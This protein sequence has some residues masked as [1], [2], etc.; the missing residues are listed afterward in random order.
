MQFDYAS[1]K[2]VGTKP[3]PTMGD[4]PLLKG[5][6]AEL[7][8][9][10]GS[11]GDY[12]QMVAQIDRLAKSD[13]NP[14]PHLAR[15]TVDPDGVMAKIAAE[16]RD[17]MRTALTKRFTGLAVIKDASGKTVGLPGEPGSTVTE[18][19]RKLARQMRSILTD[20]EASRL[21]GAIECLDVPLYC[22]ISEAALSRASA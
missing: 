13:G 10:V 19:M 2:F 12:D 5:V 4:N 1:G 20:D 3:V 17:E 21:E 16:R 14:W 9:L 18:R 11:V 6:P 22:Q 15:T 7:A 8:D